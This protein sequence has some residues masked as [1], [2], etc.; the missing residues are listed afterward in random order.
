MPPESDADLT[1][2]PSEILSAEERRRLTA[3]PASSLADF[4]KPS[5]SISE[6]HASRARIRV[7]VGARGTG[8]TTAI[9]VEAIGQCTHVPGAKV[10]VLRKTQ[11][12]NENTTQ[13]TFD[14]V[15]D[16][17]G[18][19]DTGLSLFKKIEGGK[20]Y[21]IPSAEALRLFNI[22]LAKKPN[23]TQIL[24]WLETIGN[25]FCGHIHFAGVPDASKRDSRFRGYE[26]SMLIFVEADQLGEDDFQM[27][28][29]CLRWKDAYGKQIDD[30]SCILDTNPPGTKHWIAK[31]EADS[32]TRS[33]VRIWHLHIDENAH[34][35]PNGYVEAAKQVYAKRPAMYKRMIEGQYADAFEGEPVLWA[36]SE[37]HA[38]DDLPW[39]R[40]AYL[41]RGW[42]FGTTHSVIFSAYWSEGPDEYWWDLWEHYAEMSDVERQCRAV[43]EITKEVFPFFNDRSV[44]A[45]VFD[46]CDPAGAQKTDKGTSI[47]VLNTNNIYPR[48]S[49][50]YRSLPLTLTAYNR[51]LEKRD[52]FGRLVYRVDRKCCERLYLAS[53]GG[54]RYPVEGEP[55]FKSGEPGKGPGFGNFDHLADASR[56]GKVNFLRLI[57]VVM[58]EAQK[59]VGKLA[60]KTSLNPARS[61]R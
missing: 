41:V 50:K 31:F 22:F 3:T 60:A 46:A 10:Y 55:G 57:K 51:L 5:K 23:K 34:N 37:E 44:C 32:K 40:G 36:F 24:Q 14:E 21:R 2:L 47:A 28:Q 52:R 56:Y 59:P 35:L 38:Y 19:T 9:A 13:E 49:T 20:Y 43:T 1:A 18:Y 58:E 33:D 45:G 17:C 15:F 6:F 42:D 16:K 39:P 48:Y 26:C 8:K 30:Y 12:S 11:E 29:L 4:Y 53:A 27:A 25:R 7:L 54:Y 61:W